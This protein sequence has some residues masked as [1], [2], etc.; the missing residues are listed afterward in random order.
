MITSGIK[1]PYM[2]KEQ[3]IRCRIM[4]GGGGGEEG[5]ERLLLVEDIVL[6]RDCLP[7]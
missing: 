4:R 3:V 1:K 7:M 5:A 6:T 2:G